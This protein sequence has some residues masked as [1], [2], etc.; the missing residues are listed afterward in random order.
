MIKLKTWKQ[1]LKHLTSNEF[2]FLRMMCRLSK[3][4]Y[5][6]SLYNIR[7]HYFSE[8]AYLRYEANYPLMKSS[9]NYSLLGANIAQQSM[10]CADTSFKSFFGL[11]KLAKSGKYES[12]KIRLPK[13]LPKDGFYKLCLTQAGIKNGSFLVP[14]SPSMKKKTD[15]RLRIAVPKY[16]L[17]KKIHQIHIIPKHNGHYFEVAYM[18]DDVEDDRNFELDGNKALGID[19]G[20]NNFATCVTDSGESFIIDGRKIKSINQWYNKQLARLSSIKDK[21]KIK[22]FT[23]QQYLITRK[24][25]NRVQDFMYCAAKYIVNYCLSH[26]IGNIVVGYNDGFQDRVNLGRVN[27]QNFV[28]LPYGKFKN[29]LEYLCNKHG[30]HFQQQEESY[31]S[32]A[33]FFD[34]DEIPKWNP[35]NPVSAEFSGKRVTRGTY[36]TSTGYKLNADV[37]GALNIL[38]KSNLVDLSVLQASGE[39]NT[40]LRIRKFLQTSHK[41]FN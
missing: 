11:L 2:E 32:K 27:N 29:R 39:V 9:E 16:L 28:M 6:E 21:Q 40:P 36:K 19:F 5:N 25:N 1:N 26:K 30:I 14:T 15:V 37:N 10:R 33:S 8:G 7:Q 18:F 3:N 31:T 17:D 34:N 20:I 35:L 23:K 24:R 22:K 4:V 41:E 12:W 13:Y 38:R